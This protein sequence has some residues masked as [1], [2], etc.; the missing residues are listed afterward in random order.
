M[1][2]VKGNL[3]DYHN[4]YPVVITTNGNVKLSGAVMGKG[5]AFEAKNRFPGLPKML[6]QH[7]KMSGN[8]VKYFPEFNLFTFPTKNN[9]WEKSDLELITESCDRLLYMMNFLGNRDTW[10]FEKV[11]MVRPGCNNGQLSWEIVKPVLEHY[12]DDRFIIVNK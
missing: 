10:T 7:I 1:L 4:P 5:I 6:A 8:V 11:Y 12:F 3:W 2:E 9:W